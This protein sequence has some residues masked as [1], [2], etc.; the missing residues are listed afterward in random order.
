ME[1]FAGWFVDD[2]A[3]QLYAIPEY[4]IQEIYDIEMSGGA[5][6]STAHQTHHNPKHSA[7]T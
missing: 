3:R 5:S 6:S 2:E 7:Q 4:R 1:I